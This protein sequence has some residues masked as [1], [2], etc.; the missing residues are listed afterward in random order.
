MQTDI[1]CLP[2]PC[3]H[4]NRNL[5]TLPFGE[6][7]CREPGMNI[8]R[9]ICAG[10]LMLAGGPAA[11]DGGEAGPKSTGG[12]GSGTPGGRLP[13]YRD[14]LGEVLDGATPTL[15]VSPG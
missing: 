11:E 6:Q 13:L 3:F 8:A 12:P 5:P 4:T 15:S 1:R 14:A 10:V 2:N 9:I 7:P